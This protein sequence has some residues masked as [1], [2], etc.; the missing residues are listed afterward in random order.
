MRQVEF[1]RTPSA[2]FNDEE[3]EMLSIDDGRRIAAALAE[4]ESLHSAQARPALTVGR[5]VDESVVKA[6]N[7]RPI[8]ASAAANIKVEELSADFFLTGSAH[9]IM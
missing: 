9:H 7:A 3:V 5:S 8:S 4:Q 2:L 6:P 1:S